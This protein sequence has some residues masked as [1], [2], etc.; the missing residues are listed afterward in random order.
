M[1][2][3]LDCLDSTQVY[4]QENNTTYRT[5]SNLPVFSDVEYLSAEYATNH[6]DFNT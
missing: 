4:S 5:P 2:E 6:S 3:A 1:I